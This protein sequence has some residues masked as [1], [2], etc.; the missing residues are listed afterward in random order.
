MSQ[1]ETNRASRVSRAVYSAKSSAARGPSGA[2][3]SAAAAVSA[4]FVRGM[5]DKLDLIAVLKVKE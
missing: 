5:L 3:M 2:R 4:L 1:A